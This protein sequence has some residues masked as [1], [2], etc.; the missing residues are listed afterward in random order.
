[1]GRELLLFT[2]SIWYGALLVITYDILTICR[3]VI[4]HSTAFIAFEDL[5]YW[6]FCALFLF[7]RFF[8]ENSGI[9]RG[10]LAAGI[11]VGSL[12]CYFSISPYF[13]RFFTFLSKKVLRVLEIPLK[14]VRKMMKRLKSS[15]F[16]GKMF[17]KRKISSGKKGLGRH[18]RRNNKGEADEEN[19]KGRQKKTRKR[20]KQEE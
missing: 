14:I 5:I 20:K 3:N 15:L 4:R 9:L 19:K 12:A 1:M 6:I 17:V 2:K 8:K 13:V 11:L 10:Y 18:F 16:Q 7:S